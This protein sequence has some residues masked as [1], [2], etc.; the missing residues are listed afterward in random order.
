MAKNLYC[1]MTVTTFDPPN[2]FQYD[3]MEG[4]SPLRTLELLDW[5]EIMDTF[6]VQTSFQIQQGSCSPIVN[7]IFG[8]CTKV[9]CIQRVHF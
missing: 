7:D 5:S 9:R 4:A 6:N 1:Q 8:D 3:S 2:V